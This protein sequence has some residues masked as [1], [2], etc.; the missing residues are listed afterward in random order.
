MDDQVLMAVLGDHATLY[1]TPL[2]AAT[3]RELVE[4]DSL[5]G[6]HGYFVLKSSK[7]EGREVVEILAKAPSF[8]AAGDLFDLIIGSQRRAFAF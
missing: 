6:G 4:D 7:H 1:V 8:E 5:G 3:C 2:D